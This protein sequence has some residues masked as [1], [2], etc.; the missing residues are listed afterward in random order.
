MQKVDYSLCIIYNYLVKKNIVKILL[1]VLLIGLLIVSDLLTKIYVYGPIFDGNTDIVLINGV[2]RF[3]AVQNTGASFG[4]FSNHTMVLSIIS[5]IT[6]TA[7][8]GFLI[9]SVKKMPNA[10]FRI[11]LSLIVAGG[12]GNLVDRFS[13]G[14]VR[15]FIYFE[16]IDFAVFNIA[17]SCL[18]IGCILLIFYILLDYVFKKPISDNNV[19]IE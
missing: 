1:E 16:L 13:L 5:L 8:F 7:A 19:E 12:I 2:L 10:L 11:S 18:T 4:M 3:T 17:D 14:Y 15:D 9:F 6:V